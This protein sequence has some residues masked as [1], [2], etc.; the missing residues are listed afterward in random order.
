MKNKLKTKKKKSVQAKK[1]EDDEEAHDEQE[2][3]EEGEGNEGEQEN[4]VHRNKASSAL[5]PPKKAKLKRNT[6]VKEEK[7][8]VAETPEN[9]KTL[10]KG[11]HF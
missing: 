1:G 3:E 4:S 9:D 8:D 7:L 2:E 6:Q 5:I 11:W 10:P